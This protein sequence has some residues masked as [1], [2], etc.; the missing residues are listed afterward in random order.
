MSRLPQEVKVLDEFHKFLSANGIPLRF[1]RGC[2]FEM[3][4]SGLADFLFAPDGSEGKTSPA[5]RWRALLKGTTRGD[6]DMV[7]YTLLAWYD[8]LMSVRRRRGKARSASATARA[9]AKRATRAKPART[10][11]VARQG[12]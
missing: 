4:I 11:H 8:S 1:G 2:R 6:R 5:A 3:P 9:E 7:L 10:R 12:P